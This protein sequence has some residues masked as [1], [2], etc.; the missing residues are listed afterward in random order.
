MITVEKFNREIQGE[1][2]LFEKKKKY[3]LDESKLIVETVANRICHNLYY[4]SLISAYIPTLTSKVLPSISGEE[5]LEERQFINREVE[6]RRNLPG[7]YAREEYDYGE[8]FTKKLQELD[9]LIIIL[10]LL[11]V[12]H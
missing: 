1:K 12:C 11:K 4:M 10:M 8:F 2:L 3:S 6:R 5:L 7:Q 9:V